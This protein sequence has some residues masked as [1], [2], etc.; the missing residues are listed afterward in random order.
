MNGGTSGHRLSLLVSAGWVLSES[1]LELEVQGGGG[2]A[3]HAEHV[4]GAEVGLEGQAPKAELV[5]GYQRTGEAR[6]TL[7]RDGE[8]AGGI[9]LGAVNAV[10][11]FGN[12]EGRKA[13]VRGKDVVLVPALQVG[14]KAP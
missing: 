6:A 14:Q 8:G 7:G 5:A 3:A 13:Q 2:G 4:G 11:P 12:A 1:G 9:A 10:G